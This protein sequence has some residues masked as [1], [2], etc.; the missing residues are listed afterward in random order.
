MHISS[1]CM[2]SVSH[3]TAHFTWV[4]CQV[5]LSTVQLLLTAKGQLSYLPKVQLFLESDHPSTC[6]EARSVTTE[7]Q[8]DDL[9]SVSTNS[10]NNIKKYHFIWLWNGLNITRRLKYSYE[11]FSKQKVKAKLHESTMYKA[12]ILCNENLNIIQCE[13]NSTQSFG[14]QGTLKCSDIENL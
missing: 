1:K 14:R 3:F 12:V 11:D 2:G 7:A 6:I 13:G 9:A 8:G 5:K 4:C 10:C